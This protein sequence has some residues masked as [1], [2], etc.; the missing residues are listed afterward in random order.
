[1]LTGQSWSPVK[2]AKQFVAFLSD[3]AVSDDGLSDSGDCVELC[4][5]ML[6]FFAPSSTYAYAFNTFCCKLPLGLCCIRYCGVPLLL[7]AIC[8]P[9]AHYSLLLPYA[10]SA[11]SIVGCYG[12]LPC[13]CILATIFLG[14]SGVTCEDV[15]APPFF[16]T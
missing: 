7:V 12:Q 16:S 2:S 4:C 9:H 8:G 6:G 13:H 3:R 10:V 1:M 11:C 15:F 5:Y 14:L